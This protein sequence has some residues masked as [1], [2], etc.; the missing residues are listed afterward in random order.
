[1]NKFQVKLED[2][3]ILNYKNTVKNHIGPIGLSIDE[4]KNCPGIEDAVYAIETMRKT[5]NVRAH[6]EKVYFTRLPYMAETDPQHLEEIEAWGEEVKTSYDNV[7][8]LGIGGSYLGNQVLVDSL[9]GPQWNAHCKKDNVPRI[10]FSGNNADPSS[11]ERLAEIIDLDKTMFVVISK[12][13]TTTETMASFL[14]FYNLYYKKGLPIE[15]HF[16]V[17]TDPVKGILREIAMEKGLKSF[18]V[19]EGVGG[20]WSVLSD[21][22]LTIAS[23]AGI[24]IRALLKGAQAMDI[25]CQEGDVLK[26]PALIY[27]VICFSLYKKR[28]IHESILMPYCDALKSFS[29]WYVQLLAESLGK[30]KNR[31]GEIVNEGRT[32]IA[33]V[34]TSDMHSQTQQHREGKRN[35]LLTT[36]SVESFKDK[37]VVLPREDNLGGKLSFLTGI[38]LA[39]ILHAARLA[40]E[41][42]LADDG[43]PSCS[44]SIPALEAYTQ[45][46]LFYFFELSTAYEGEFLNVNA[47]DQPGVEH[48]KKIMKQILKERQKQ[49]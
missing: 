45:G 27:A 29:L 23:A 44:I 14:Y 19:P 34:G 36:I 2:G 42:A 41:K 13:G 12:S 25:A 38:R 24:D 31:N 9:L 47:Y 46:E 48:Y 18:N 28:D 16:T 33:A 11:L 22:G 8:S 10:F 26:N 20:R 21:V 39:D 15:K 3:F 37:E 32:P 17:I 4:I 5:G 35:K 40:N 49:K 7:V 1:M 30:E 43:R 6:N